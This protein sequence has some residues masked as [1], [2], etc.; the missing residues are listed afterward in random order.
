MEVFFIALATV[1]IAEIGDKTQFVTLTLSARYRRPWPI[2]A[3]VLAASLANHGLAAVGGLWLS[4]LLPDTLITWIVGLGFIA[5]ALWTLRGD[6]HEEHA[7]EISVR[8]AF[9]T[10]FVLFFLM[11][12]GDK[13][14]IA[15]AALAANFDTV[16]WV[17]AGSTLGMLVANAPAVWLGHRYAD[18]IP[19]RLMN[20]IAAGLFLAIGL[21]VLGSALLQA[22]S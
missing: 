20:R 8:G 12:M 3:G 10:T 13:T 11:E 1:A 17:V 6:H 4:R 5:M 22:M 19:A 15:T 21:W 7:P 2:L 14:Q 16:V 18:R 9:L